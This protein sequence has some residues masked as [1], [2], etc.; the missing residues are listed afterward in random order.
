MKRNE[1]VVGEAYMWASTNGYTKKKVVVISDQPHTRHP[2]GSLFGAIPGGRGV[3]VEATYYSVASD[4]AS[5]TPCQEVVQLKDIVGPF[6][7]ERRRLQEREKTERRREDEI[8]RTREENNKALFAARARLADL[9]G[10][11]EFGRITWDTERR[12]ELTLAEVEAIIAR[13]SRV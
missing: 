3:L 7:E 6:E 13:L 5:G 4:S 12:C 10:D 8:L 2:K 11:P 9:M 1:L